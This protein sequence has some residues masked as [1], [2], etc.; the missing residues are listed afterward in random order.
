VIEDSERGLRAAKAAG[1]ACWV[2][3]TA[4][5]RRGDFRAAD[6]VLGSVGDVV[7]GLMS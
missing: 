6:R 3:P 7:A 2:I 4:L 5:T 1:I